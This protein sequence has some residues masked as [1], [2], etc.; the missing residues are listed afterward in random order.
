[1]EAKTNKNKVEKVE[2]GCNFMAK[3]FKL[4]AIKL[5][6]SS[7]VHSLPIKTINNPQLNE[8]KGSPNHISKVPTEPQQVKNHTPLDSARSSIQQREVNGNSLGLARISTTSR[9]H[10]DNENKSPSK[11]LNSVKL[12]GNLLMNSSY[13]SPRTSVTKINKEMN[14][15]SNGV[16]GNIIRKS[17][18]GVSQFRSP[19]SDRVLDP[20]VLKS[21]GNEAYKQGRFSEALALYER[22][23]AIDSNKATYHCNKSAALIGLGRFQQAIV[24]CEE[25]IRIQPSYARAHSR[26]ATIYFRLGEAEKA[27]NCNKETPYCDSDLAFKAHALQI[28]LNKCSEARKVNDWKFILT[29]TKSA[30]SLGVDSAPKVYALQTEALLKLLRHQEAYA[31]YEKMPKFD[32]DWCNKLFGADFSAYFLMIGAQI[33]LATGRFE[34]AVTASQRASKLDPSNSDVN[35][36]VRRARAA[37][38]ARLSGNLLFKASKFTEACAVYNEGLEHDPFNSVLLC[39]RA[40]CRSKLGQFEKA[41]EDCNIALKIQ[42]SYSKAMLRR[43]DC[44]AKLERW[45][46]AIQDYE[47]LIREKPGDEEVARALFEIQLKQKMLRGEDIKNLKFGS[48]LVCISSNDRFRHYVTSPGMSVVLFCNKGKATHKQILLVLEQT[49]KRFPSVNFL[50]VEIEDHPYLTKSEGV[51]TIPAFKIYKNGSRVKEISGNNHE[52]LERSVKLYSS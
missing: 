46:A 40:A 36:V 6:N 25:A 20:E 2:L 21:M 8:S 34:D 24:E 44:N 10:R 5:R 1:M 9:H 45:E 13:I 42:P 14:S 52:L 35:A 26:L 39:N 31:T 32:H 28:H 7:S 50:K 38:S 48:N 37:T 43:A 23:I 33:Y 3:I 18:D 22:A 41:I 30:I 29:E 51:N 17:G 4:K 11:D 16:M 12:T 49:C 15:V 19:R 27:L 47:M